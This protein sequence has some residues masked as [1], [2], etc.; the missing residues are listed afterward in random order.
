MKKIIVASFLIMLAVSVAAQKTFNGEN[1]Q[2]RNVSSFHGIN[3]ATGIELVMVQ[4]NSEEV[5]VSAATPEFRDKIVTKV[6]NGI[7]RIYY[8]DKLKARN[9]RKVKKELKAWVSYKSIDELNATTG[10]HVTIEDILKSSSLKMKVNTGAQVTGK[11][12]TGSLSISQSTG[13]IARLSGDAQKLEADG[14]TGSLFKGEDL[15]SE[16]CDVKVSTGAGITI[17]A[18]KELYAKANTGGSVKYKGDAS[19]REIKKGTGGN[20]S[21]M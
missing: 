12:S 13:S 21:K 5:A 18:D 7:L 11:V 4:G 9:T 1:A 20:V 19:V 15:R 6:E 8:E 3:V 17:T 10:A 16:V 2:K 14:S